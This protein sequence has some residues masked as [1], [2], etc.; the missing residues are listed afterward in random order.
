MP[1]F[2]PLERRVAGC[3]CRLENGSEIFSQF[4]HRGAMMQAIAH[5]VNDQ[6]VAWRYQSAQ[7][8]PV[9]PVAQSGHLSLIHI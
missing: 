7:F 8:L 9:T 4:V 2:T 3:S 1:A 5:P 6:E